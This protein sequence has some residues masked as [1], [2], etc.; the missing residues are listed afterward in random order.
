M[1]ASLNDG[2]GSS[3]YPCCRK[4]TVSTAAATEV[5]PSSHPSHAINVGGH[6]K[7]YFVH[8]KYV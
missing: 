2:S 8:I 7:S 1:R 4:L 3:V 6:D 5:M